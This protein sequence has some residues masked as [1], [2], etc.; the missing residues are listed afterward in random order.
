MIDIDARVAT[1]TAIAAPASVG[2]K[3]RHC[4]RCHHNPNC[5]TAA[6][7][8]IFKLWKVL[9]LM[10]TLASPAIAAIATP[11]ATTTLDRLDIVKGRG[12]LV[13][14]AVLTVGTGAAA[15]AAAIA[16]Q[17]QGRNGKYLG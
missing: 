8:T 3:T 4:H 9:L 2:A 7:A 14:I 17:G 13:E 10:E 11:P 1:V 15:A 5:V 12:V 6:E 16:C